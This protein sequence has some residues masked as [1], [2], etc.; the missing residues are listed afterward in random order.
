MHDSEIPILQF[1]PDRNAVIQPGHASKA[2]EGANGIVLSFFSETVEG[3][4]E[5]ESLPVVGSI[6][7]EMG[8]HRVYQI[9]REG[10]SL[11]LFQVG[12]GAPLAAGQLDELLGMG[13]RSVIVC[14]SAG[15]LDSGIDFARIMICERAVR[16]EG[17]S[18][19]YLPAG[20]PSVAHPQ[21]VNV[22]EALLEEREI[23][24][25][26]GQSWTTDAFYRETPGK[27]AR[28][29]EEG[30]SMVEMEASALFAVARYRGARIGQ[31]LYGGDDVSGLEWDPRSWG[32]KKHGIRAQLIELSLTAAATLAQIDP[33][34][35]VE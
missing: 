11:G 21:A 28:R 22:L 20:E 31:M 17:T 34:D 23:P 30:C 1:D 6:R 12:V 9:E 24:H 35:A 15:V 33:A 3:I 32:D 29:R 16:D 7:S 26:K 13:Y 4:A 2:V 27:V 19:H 14:G 5:R 25:F 18:Y 8:E 10:Q